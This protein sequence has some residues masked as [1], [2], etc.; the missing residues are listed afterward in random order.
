MNIAPIAGME[1]EEIISGLKR[2][3][4]EKNGYEAVSTVSGELSLLVALDPN[5]GGGKLSKAAKLGVEVMSLDDWL[6]KIKNTDMPEE[7]PGDDLFAATQTDIKE[8]GTLF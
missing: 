7:L 1:K 2:T 5:A 6:K 8:Q 3:L 4:A